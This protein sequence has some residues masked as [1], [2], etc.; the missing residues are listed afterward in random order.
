MAADNVY[1]VAADGDDFD[2]TV[3]STVALGEYDDVPGALSGLG[4]ARVWGVDDA[5]LFAE[6]AE[7]D[8]VLFYADGRYVGVGTV[9][10]AFEDADD[11]AADALWEAASFGHC[12]TLERFAPV[13]LPRLRVHAIFD[14]SENYYP[15]TPMQV[16]DD[17]VDNSLPAIF[18]AVRR[19]EQQA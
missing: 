4:D 12:F 8:L 2:E 7:G 11:W 19:Y 14:Y 17:R 6:M 13:D 16:P 5:D 15:S 3:A 18:E 1:V 9:G 10:T